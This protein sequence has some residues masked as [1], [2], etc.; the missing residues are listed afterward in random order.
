[1]DGIYANCIYFDFFGLLACTSAK[2]YLSIVQL[3]RID[4]NDIFAC[5]DYC[6]RRIRFC[7]K[8]IRI[9]GSI[10]D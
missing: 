10:T 7:M 4:I 3:N 1:M 8:K 5:S 9:N 6:N 2:Q